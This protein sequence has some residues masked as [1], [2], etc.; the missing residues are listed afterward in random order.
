MRFYTTMTTFLPIAAVLHL[1]AGCTASGAHFYDTPFATQ[2][3]GPDKARII[4][5]RDSD[6]NFRAATIGIDGSRIGAVHHDGFI[7]AE[8][9][10]GEHKISAWVRGSFQEFVT[11][12]SFEPGKAY[13]IRV[14][15]RSERLAYPM[16]PILG[17]F[18]VLADTKGEFQLELMPESTALQQLRDLKLSE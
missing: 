1:L 15:Q 11:S 14:S 9:E 13:Y 5:Y 12:M 4:F 2:P 8:V 18:L 7:V 16:V 6:M 3:V 17:P 10:P